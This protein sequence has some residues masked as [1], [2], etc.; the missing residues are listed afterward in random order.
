MFDRIWFRPRV[1]RN[2]RDVDTGTRLLSVESGIPVFVSPAALAKLVH[3]EGEKAIARGCLEK[4]II[5]CVST[6][7]SYPIEE[8]LASAPSHPFFF[9]LYVNKDRAKTEALLAQLRSLKNIAVIFVTVDAPVAGKREADE[10]VRADET[11]STPMSGSKAVND[12]RGG[13]LGRIMGSYIDASLSWDDLAWLRRHWDGPM[14][15]KGVQGA[16]DAQRAM[17]EGLQGVVLSNHGGRSLDT[18]PPA[19]LILLELQRC[20]PEVFE[21]MEV[22]VDGGVRRGTDVLKALCLGATAVGIG[23]S[24]LYALN[25]GQDGVEHMIDRESPSHFPL[26][27]TRV[28]VVW[29]L[30]GM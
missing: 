19:I 30:K 11:L 2:V 4:G 20:C 14:V 5:Q 9:Q 12:K 25:Y 27:L 21:R 15:L 7:A 6:N 13:G 16:A 24:F 23:R 26:E 8:I 17:H 1:M 3:P 22:Y 18:S 28:V 10:R 29:R